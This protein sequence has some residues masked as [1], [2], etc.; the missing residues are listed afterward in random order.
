MNLI[1]IVA[2]CNVN[3]IYISIYITATVILIVAECN[4]NIDITTSIILSS[5]F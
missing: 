5:L 3:I 4:V 1:L 2:E